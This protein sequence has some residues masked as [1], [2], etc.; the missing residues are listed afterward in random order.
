[1]REK[2]ASDDF[3]YLRIQKPEHLLLY[4]FEFQY[5]FHIENGSVFNRLGSIRYKI[6]FSTLF[7][8]VIFADLLFYK[9]LSFDGKHAVCPRSLDP[10]Y[11]LTY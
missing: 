10:I 11:I 4:N 2:N 9:L 1:M 7:E 5:F 6:E 8:E 3:C